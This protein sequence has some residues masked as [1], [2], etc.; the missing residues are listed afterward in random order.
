MSILLKTSDGYIRITLKNPYDF[1][2]QTM[3]FFSRY[4]NRPTSIS[5]T[6]SG[7]YCLDL[8]GYYGDN[9]RLA[10]L[11]KAGQVLADTRK[12]EYERTRSSDGKIDEDS[13]IDPTIQPFFGPDEAALL[14]AQIDYKL[15]QSQAEAE[16]AAKAQ[17]VSQSDVGATG[18][19]AV[20]NAASGS[21]AGLSVGDK[22]A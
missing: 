20:T 11:M 13:P 18:D 1:S 5:E 3:K 6:N 17:A 4:V 22:S 19:T 2:E 8:T 16:L 12:I 9:A 21:D 7:E 10:G 14:K 15:A